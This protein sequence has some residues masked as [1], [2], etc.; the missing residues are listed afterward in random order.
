[1]VVYEI[2]K[3]R[4]ALFEFWNILK[5]GTI[6]TVLF[7]NSVDKWASEYDNLLNESTYRGIKLDGGIRFM[8]SLRRDWAM[9]S[10]EYQKYNCYRF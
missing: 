2:K 6:D 1:M 8:L 4:E 7:Y 10:Y 5:N 3:Q 9:A